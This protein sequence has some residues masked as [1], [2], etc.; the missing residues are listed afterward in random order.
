MFKIALISQGK[1][2][3]NQEVEKWL[4]FITEKGDKIEG[5]YCI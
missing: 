5:D 3:Y 1:K 4:K 2:S